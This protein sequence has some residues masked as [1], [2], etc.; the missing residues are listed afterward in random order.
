MNLTDFVAELDSRAQQV[1]GTP[2]DVRLAGIRRRRRARRA[3]A[4]AGVVV[5]GA[6]VGVVG[7]AV[8]P[9]RGG[10]RVVRPAW[11]VPFDPDDAG[12][13]LVASGQAAAR[14][15]LVLRF[16]PRDTDLAMT[17]Y[18]LGTPSSPDERFE[19]SVT[20]NDRAYIRGGC[21]P[22][23][24]GM[25]TTS[26]GRAEA[27]AEN[28]AMWADIGVVPGRESV[29]RVSVT[30][31]GRADEIGVAFYE[32]SGPRVTSDGVRLRERM[33][34]SGRDYRLDG[35]RTGPATAGRLVLSGTGP[36]VVL[37][38]MDGSDATRQQVLL[39][40][41]PVSWGGVGVGTHPAPA[42][43]STSEVRVDPPVAGTLVVAYYVPDR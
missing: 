35:F 42:G 13:P 10:D 41:Q 6:A 33:S 25:A 9:D 30:G 31:S 4:V 2:S 5:V 15:E 1:R 36:G 23:V 37:A 3:R 8:L 11:R 19:F 28:R 21:R 24:R 38:G 27:V 17:S 39:D 12:D 29:V 14:R 43:R 20:V 18:C 26:F 22:D 32:R 16:T 40:G 7:L 34:V